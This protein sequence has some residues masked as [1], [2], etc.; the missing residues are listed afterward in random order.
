MG[1]ETPSG[2]S[3]GMELALW[4]AVR[5]RYGHPADRIGA[6]RRLS[7]GFFL[8]LALSERLRTRPTRALGQA[9]WIDAGYCI[10][11]PDVMPAGACRGEAVEDVLGEDPVAMPFQIEVRRDG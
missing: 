4:G 7:L 10:D 3:R 6:T 2:L 1:A 5:V 8:R 11:A 9:M